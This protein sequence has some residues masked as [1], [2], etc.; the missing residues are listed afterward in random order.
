MTEKHSLLPWNNQDQDKLI[1]CDQEGGSIA[2]CV[3]PG[4]WMSFAT[5]EANAALIVRSVN[6]LPEAI[7]ALEA[8]RE[9][10]AVDAEGCAPG[11]HG[12]QLLV[13]QIDA[14]LTKLKG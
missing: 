12:A 9:S 2:D 8:A 4:P 6:G 11:W 10:L 3:P 5:A 13:E 14:A 1:V 7:A